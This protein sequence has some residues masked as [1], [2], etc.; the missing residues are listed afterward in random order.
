MYG[1]TKYMEVICKFLTAWRASTPN[2]PIVQVQLYLF[3]ECHW[4]PATVASLGT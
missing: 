2:P 1:G 4:G 3:I